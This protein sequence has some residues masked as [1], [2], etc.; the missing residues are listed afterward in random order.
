MS[1]FILLLRPPGI[2][3]VGKRCYMRAFRVWLRA[4]VCFLLSIDASL[5]LES[6]F[7]GDNPVLEFLWQICARVRTGLG[8]SE[9]ES[10]IA[11]NPPKAPCAPLIPSGVS[12]N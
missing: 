4:G 5:Y 2:S 10:S 7:F 12:R 9:Q 3:P 8:L 1:L 6:L 11:V